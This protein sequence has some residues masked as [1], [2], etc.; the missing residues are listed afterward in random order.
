VRGVEVNRG[1]VA[2]KVVNAVRNHFAFAR[3]DEIVIERLD[4]LLCVRLART[5]KIAQLFFLFR[6][7]ADDGIAGGLVLLP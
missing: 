3:A 4:S 6:V 5:M 1:V 7:D 2:G